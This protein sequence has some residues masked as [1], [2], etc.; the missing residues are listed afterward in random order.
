MTTR[1]KLVHEF[2]TITLKKFVAHLNDPMLN[3]MLIEGLS[4][5]ER[6]LVKKEKNGDEITWQFQVKKRSELPP[7]IKKVLK[8]DAFGWS[9]TSRFVPKDHC[10][11][12]R[13]EP[14]T[15]I[16][17]F[18]GEGVWRLKA[19]NQ[20]CVRTI[21]GEVS[22]EIPLVGKVV[23]EFIVNEL[24]KSYDIEPSIQEQFYAQV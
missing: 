17:K 12:W 1:F 5:E 14:L 19:K 21:E 11:Y 7:I 20:G 9:E 4:F 16:V 6:T 10:I 3:D 23:E 13:I 22:V 8:S 24:I 18:F 2:R 15:K